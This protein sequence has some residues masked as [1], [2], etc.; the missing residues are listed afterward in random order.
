[1]TKPKRSKDTSGPGSAYR[2]QQAVRVR[3]LGQE[4]VS[5]TELTLDIE[6]KL[7][8]QGR[9][10]R[11]TLTLRPPMSMSDLDIEIHNLVLAL[12]DGHGLPRQL[13]HTL[14]YES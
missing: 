12:L 4:S 3:K 8:G 13:I 7:P 5:D 14:V 11:R 1:M 10:E 9:S 6:I 2:G